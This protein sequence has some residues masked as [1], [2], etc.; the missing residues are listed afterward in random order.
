MAAAKKTDVVIT[1]TFKPSETA[2]AILAM[3]STLRSMFLWGPPG[4]SKSAVSK[5]V[6]TMLGIAFIDVRLSQM[7]PTDLRGIPYPVTVGGVSGVDWSTPLVLPRNLDIRN[8]VDIEG[9]ESEIDFYNP[10]GSN[11]IHYCT[12]PQF[13]VQSLTKGLEAKLLKLA[14]NKA[15]VALY[16][17][18][19]EIQPGRIAFSVKGTVH[20]ILALE[21]FNS[22]PPSVQAAAYQ[23]I[24]DRAL[25]A[26]EVPDG[27]YIIAMGNRDTDKGVT[28]KMPTPIMNR[29]VHAEMKHD[30]DDWILW[31]LGEMIHPDVV[32]F[33]GAMPD[34]LFQF[35]PGTAARGFQTPRS[36]HFVSDILAKADT[37]PENVLRGLIIGAVGDA[38]GLLM[39][40]HR[41]NAKD[42]PDPKDV[43]S[44][45]LKTM[46]KKDIPV[47]LAYAMTTTLC[48][49]LKNQIDDIK[50]KYNEDKK[51]IKASPEYDRWA[52]EAD[53]F[54][55]FILTNFKPEISIMGAKAALSVH[56]L[57]FDPQRM[58]NFNVF[59]NRYKAFIL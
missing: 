4:I 48:Y 43:L 33:L 19:G 18:S 55:A 36:W 34:Q 24:L 39:M 28:F 42:M 9:M 14:S 15:I 35:N 11:G 3:R 49:I 23:L 16:D 12:D 57:P 27:V 45:Q 5:Q 46:P 59:A 54:L 10:R 52:F 32:G 58:K 37:M 25:G 20:G 26:Y 30:H 44:G 31:A 17:A 41:K 50:M 21:E 51:A 7:D 2:E 40:E 6:A 13:T 56:K 38:A 8:A 1:H 47:S 53:N 29:F 22:A